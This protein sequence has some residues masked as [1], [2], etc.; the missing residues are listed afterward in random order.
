M[1]V[2]LTEPGHWRLAGRRY[3]PREPA[4][5]LAGRN[6]SPS[7]ARRPGISAA[8]LKRATGSATGR[9]PSA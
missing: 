8:D 4:H 2:R 3:Q 5:R 9:R 6:R 7:A 1:S